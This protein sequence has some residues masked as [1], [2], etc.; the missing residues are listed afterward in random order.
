VWSITHGRHDLPWRQTTDPYQIW[1]SEIMLQQTQVS[2]VIEYYTRFLDRF[3][4]IKS[5]S[6]ASWEEFLPYYAGLGY[7]RRGQNMLKTAA[8]VMEKHSGKFPSNFTDL[9]ALP[10]VGQ[11][12]A[13]AILSFAYQQPVLAFDTNQQRVWGRL[14][15]GSKDSK[16][17]ASEIQSQIPAGAPFHTLNE[18]IMDFANLV[19]T[20]RSPRCADCPLKNRCQYF[21]TQGKLEEKVSKLTNSFPLSSAKAIVVLHENHQKYFSSNPDTFRPFILPVGQTSRQQIKQY[22]SKN[23]QLDLAVRPPHLKGYLDEQPVLVINA[24]ILLGTLPFPTF[25]R[26]DGRAYLAQLRQDLVT[27]D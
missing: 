12:T 5:L 19:C 23:Y 4:T 18:S 22:F 14:R 13:N 17:E 24:Q 21:A 8:L 2:R 9:V 11:Y 10:G 25:E 6:R 3:P 27:N 1:V 26:E 15:M 20:N 7:Y 16:V